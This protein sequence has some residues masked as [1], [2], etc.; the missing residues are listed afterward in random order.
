MSRDLRLTPGIDQFGRTI[1]DS[2]NDLFSRVGVL[3]TNRN[4]A[5]IPSVSGDFSDLQFK[6]SRLK[7]RVDAI[8]TQDPVILNYINEINSS[9]VMVV[10]TANYAIQ[11]CY[12]L[13]RKIND[14]EIKL[15]GMIYGN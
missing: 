9:L 5:S 11:R 12:E 7:S 1:Q 3:E 10:E 4:I 15:G 8:D 2:L 13:E 6:I 14:L